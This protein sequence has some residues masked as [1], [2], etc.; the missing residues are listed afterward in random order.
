MNQ[1]LVFIYIL[2]LTVGHSL[3]GA[4][5]IFAQQTPVV[6]IYATATGFPENHP[7][8]LLS[9]S[10]QGYQGPSTTIK[11]KTFYLETSLPTPDMYILQVGSPEDA[12]S[13]R[14]YSFFLDNEK[15][16]IAI[17]SETPS[18]QINS[19]KTPTAFAD[20]IAQFG[21]D[22][23]QLSVLAGLRQRA[24][25]FGF[26]SD[27]LSKEW[28]K[29]MSGMKSKIPG[30]VS[31]HA[32]TMVPSFLLNTVWPLYEDIALMDSWLALLPENA[33]KNVFG[34]ALEEAMSSERKFGYGQ[35][36]PDFVQS[37]PDGKQISLK[38]YRGKYVLVDF[39]A[40]WCGPCRR[41]NP[42]LVRSF[43]T[44]KSKNFTVL[45]ISLDKEKA[46]WLKA[47]SDDQLK[48]EQVSDLKYWSND[49]ARLYEISSIPQNFILDPEGRIIGKNLRGA[50]LD[51]FLEKN[52]PAN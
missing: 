1:K 43:N 41:E 46:N 35:I 42:N 20:L 23:D 12:A 47:I 44:Y 14:Q 4:N 30:F 5:S 26:Y 51:E 27:S 32:S 16:E 3:G 7:V 40:S 18:L 24:G 38:D 45:G 31:K 10:N 8:V 50:A 13:Y 36:A 19:G 28:E 21:Q 52:L 11:N 48:W 25:S 15:V 6:R 2:L 22:F 39:W 9:A 49:V 29:L 17:D 34:N 33:Q 37:N